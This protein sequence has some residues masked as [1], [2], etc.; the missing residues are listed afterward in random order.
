MSNHRRELSRREVVR[1]GL[2]ATAL[3]LAST[4]CTR[5][6]AP[7]PAP[8][9][10]PTPAAPVVATKRI[11]ILGGTGFLGP[12]TIEAALARGHTVTIFNRG[13]REKLQPLPYDVEHLYGNRD[14]ELPADDERGADGALLRPDA[15]PRGLEQLAGRA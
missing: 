6:A 7:A 11:L 2:A 4:A 14:P 1:G 10:G 12:K 3:G 8:A 5:S 15:T 9:P 13:K